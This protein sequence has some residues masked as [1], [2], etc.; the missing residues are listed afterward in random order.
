MEHPR[1]GLMGAEPYEAG[2]CKRLSKLAS[3]PPLRGE[4]G[5]EGVPEHRVHLSPPPHPNPLPRRGRGNVPS[6][7]KIYE[8]D[9]RDIIEALPDAS[10]GRF[11]ILFPDPWPKTR[12]HKRRFIQME[13][14][15]H[16]AR[17][18]KPGAELRFA[19]DDAGYLN[20]ALERLMAHPAFHWTAT[21]A[22]DWHSRPADWPQTRYEAKRLHG[23]PAFLRFVRT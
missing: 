14:L 13:M 5:G 19:S 22:A 7:L 17:I 4:G 3:P 10:I 16:L 12:H 9:V 6:N 23:P 21:S 20:Y 15:D 8:G 11:F 18:L 1:S 2:T